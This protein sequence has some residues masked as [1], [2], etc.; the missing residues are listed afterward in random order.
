MFNVNNTHNQV[1]SALRLSPQ[2]LTVADQ[3]DLRGA[4]GHDELIHPRARFR[5]RRAH[6]VVDL[7]AGL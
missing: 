5:T 1:L 6:S 2:G 7:R 3:I 4:R